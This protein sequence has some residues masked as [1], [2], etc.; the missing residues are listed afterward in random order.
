MATERTYIWP[1]EALIGRVTSE[2]LR[3]L[4]AESEDALAELFATPR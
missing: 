3:K 1:S 2:A 4:G